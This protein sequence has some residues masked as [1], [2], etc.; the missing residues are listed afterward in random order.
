MR[1]F[2]L[3][4]EKPFREIFESLKGR[5]GLVRNTRSFYLYTIKSNATSEIDGVKFLAYSKPEGR[6]NKTK[7]VLD[8]LRQNEDKAFY[9]RQIC[10]ALKPRGV[11]IFDVLSNLRRYERKGWVLIRGY[12]GHDR[13]TPF[14][15]GYA[16]TW[17]DVEKERSEAIKEANE[18]IERLLMGE[19]T[20]NPTATRI[21][22]IRDEVV[23]TNLQRDIVSLSFLRNKVKATKHQMEKA[24][25][26][27]M[28]IY[29]D[30]RCVR[31]FN[32]P[33]YYH[34]SL[35][36]DD[37]KLAIEDKKDY[38][39]I[40]KGRDNRV[41]HNW[42][43]CV[44]WFID[45]F[46]KGAEFLEQTHR[47]RMD[48][49]RITLHLLKPVADRKINA[50]VDRV[51]TVR[52]SPISTAVTY[53]LECKWNLVNKFDLDDFLNVLRWS[54]EFGVDTSQGR[55]IKN[56]VIGILAAGAFNPT[57][58]VKLQGEV[59]S[60][61][62]Y[63]ARMNIQLLKAADLN[64]MLHERGVDKNIT[65]QKICTRARNESEAREILAR[66]WTEPVK[67]G[68]LLVQLLDRNKDVYEF[69]QMLC[70]NQSQSVMQVV[71][72]GV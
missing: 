34:S 71:N 56:G 47:T 60:L 67:A 66:I 33:Y 72:A 15:A 21:R 3:R 46:T 8:F 68:E 39:R 38:L 58:S 13:E 52:P 41:G 49:R 32:F 25:K 14:A 40:T 9:T 29:P 65:V 28:E 10:D 30:I 54:H 23:A 51:W 62:Q 36:E 45:K 44:E 20:C 26:R 42:E 16:V 6:V 55:S 7:L 1:G 4:S 61:A 53:V 11:K 35:S 27:A 50:E 17:L 69:E 31:V 22:M 48:R 5:R 63:A 57:E 18:K 70:S 64:Q 12:R 43:A 59:I 24:L 2:F 37:L 19:S